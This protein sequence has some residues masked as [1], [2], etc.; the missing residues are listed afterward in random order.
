MAI[1]TGISGLLSVL[2][3]WGVTA[4]LFALARR[5]RAVPE[6]LLAITFG[7]LFCVGYPL[8]G[9]SRVPA[10]VMTT[11]GALLFAMGSIGIVVGIAALARF[12]YVVFRAGKR[13]A[14]ALSVGIGLMGAIG[15]IGAALVVAFAPT[16]EAMI[17]EIQPWTIALMASVGASFFWNG[18]E[19]VGY[20]GKMKKRA[21]LGLSN[22]ETTHR[23]LL[24]AVASFA[25]V[26]L[27]AAIMTIRI[28]GLPILAPLGASLI[29]CASLLNTG[30]WWLAFFMPDAYRHRVLGIEPEANA[31]EGAA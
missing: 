27:I 25:S 6:R 9:A 14:A 17:A 1:F 15:G 19:S 18:L 7:G 4:R 13:W 5:T 24:W 23:F 12:P 22:P 10:M 8:T 31:A 21:A 29:S 2:V 16:R 11:E 26:A 30:C 20:Y 3:G 28:T